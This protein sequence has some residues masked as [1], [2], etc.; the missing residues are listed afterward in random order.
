MK[1]IRPA[2][3]ALTLLL[4]ACGTGTPPPPETTPTQPETP[5]QPPT[6]PVDPTPPAPVT[7][8]GQDVLYY[9]EWGWQYQ[10]TGDFALDNEGRFSITETHT[11]TGFTGSFGYYQ[12]CY[13]GTCYDRPDGGVIFGTLDG[14]L[15]AL[16]YR[17]DT[18]NDPVPVYVA[19]DKD[20]KM[21]KDSQGRNV[22]EGRAVW[23]DTVGDDR[24]G[25]FT[26]TQIDDAPV[27]VPRLTGEAET[28]VRRLLR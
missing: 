16:L 10:E 19:K 27:M 7:P 3:L 4:A 13:A 8:P 11:E 9:G 25:N 22:F 17:V 15:V 6:T 2:A 23:S 21:D 1:S 5:A 14:E 18:K 26:V 28:Q 24:N 12:T 20:G